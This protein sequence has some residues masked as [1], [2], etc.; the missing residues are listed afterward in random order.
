MRHLHRKPLRIKTMEQWD[1][2]EIRIELNFIS[3]LYDS[4]SLAVEEWKVCISGGIPEEYSNPILITDSIIQSM[5]NEYPPPYAINI[6]TGYFN[7]GASSSAQD[8]VMQIAEGALTETARKTLINT[9]KTFAEKI[10]R[11]RSVVEV[12][13]LTREEAIERAKWHIE[14]HY[15]LDRS[16]VKN[17]IT[18]ISEKE[19][20]EINEWDLTFHIGQT[21]YRCVL[22]G[23]DD[24]VFV[25][26]YG[27]TTVPFNKGK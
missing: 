8:I 2:E 5:S 16:E 14:S 13:P 1:L 6:D 24:L 20:I 4:G 7:W 22:M 18:L 9:L 27:K 21:D 17:G 26:Q 25:V 19:N 11:T 12:S 15:Q 23:R 3:D 10:C